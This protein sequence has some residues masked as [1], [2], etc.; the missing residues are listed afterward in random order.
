M[1]AFYSNSKEKNA[2]FSSWLVNTVTELNPNAI[3][4]FSTANLESDLSSV[5]GWIALSKNAGVEGDLAKAATGTISAKELGDLIEQSNQKIAYP[6][7]Y[8]NTPENT[9]DLLKTEKRQIHLKC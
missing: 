4:V 9:L 2:E 1:N 5:D 8:V 7:T 3:V 6:A